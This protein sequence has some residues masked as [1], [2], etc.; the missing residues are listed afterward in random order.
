MEKTNYQDIIGQAKRNKKPLGITILVLLILGLVLLMVRGYGSSDPL[1]E[2]AVETEQVEM[3]SDLEQLIFRIQNCSRLYT[4]EYQIH[5]IITHEDQAQLNMVGLKLTLPLT[6]RHIAIPMDA[7]LKAYVDLGAF[8]ASNIQ[9][10]GERVI[11]TLP[12]PHIEVISTLVDHDKTKSHNSFF[13]SKYSAKEQEALHRQ[14]LN[15]IAKNI[16]NTQILEN[17]RVSAAR[18][19]IPMITRMGYKEENIRINYSKEAFDQ[20]DLSRLVDGNLFKIESKKE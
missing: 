14:G 9:I 15:S 8:S 16:L 5:K 6:D 2:N 20:A 11:V 13:S 17:A 19:L 3:G 12:D 4:T 18:T 1:V 10:D 7:T